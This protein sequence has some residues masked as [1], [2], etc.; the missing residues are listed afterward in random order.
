ML[1]AG[2]GGG[3]G[4]APAAGQANPPV[5]GFLATFGIFGPIFQRPFR[6]TAFFT[7]INPNW[8][9]LFFYIK[10]TKAKKW[11]NPKLTQKQ[12]SSQKSSPTVNGQIRQENPEIFRNMDRLC[13]Q[14]EQGQCIVASQPFQRHKERL[15]V[16]IT[17]VASSFFYLSGV[18]GASTC[19]SS[20]SAQ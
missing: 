5:P 12:P 16:V 11:S 18:S 15:A 4:A 8:F 14:V 6:S 2:R 3:G 9:F 13:T 7:V 20:R 17:A 10:K 1:A 19:T